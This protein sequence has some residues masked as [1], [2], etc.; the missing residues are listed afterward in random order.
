M[1]KYTTELRSICESYAGLKQEVGYNAVASVIEQAR[2]KIFDFNY[3][4]FDPN[5]KSVLE[6][7]IIQHYYT[8][9]ISVETVGLWK[10]RLWSKMCDIMPYYNQLYESA[11]LQYNPLYDVEYTKEGTRD[12]EAN[13]TSDGTGSGNVHVTG[14]NTERA[15]SKRNRQQDETGTQAE[16]TRANDKTETE[17]KS[18]ETLQG[19]ETQTRNLK[20]TETET[21]KTNSTENENANYDGT[22]T[23][24]STAQHT[25]TD[26]IT[27][28]TTV[29]GEA[30][31]N[32]TGSGSTHKTTTHSGSD[33]LT[34]SGTVKTVG[35]S[36][37]TDTE[38]RNLST[39]LNRK[40]GTETS[41]LDTPQNA[42]ENLIEDGY[43]TS[44]TKVD[45][46]ENSI[47]DET[48]TVKHVKSDN[49]NS[50]STTDLEHET[51]YGH[52]ILE[53]G[54]QNWSENSKTDTSE[55]TTGKSVETKNLTDT[56]NGTEKNKN[57]NTV[58]KSTES[59]VSKNSSTDETGT[60]KTDRTNETNTTGTGVSI[61]ESNSNTTGETTAKIKET[62]SSESNRTA[63]NKQETQTNST[64]SSKE[65]AL[66]LDKYLEKIRGRNGTR[67]PARLIMEYRETFLN[68]DMMVIN[69]LAE[70]FFML[71]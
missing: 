6:T 40:T 33:T 44:F 43:L 57:T 48:G 45:G 62:D 58:D 27:S 61:G 31:K 24:N 66:T 10:M 50:T 64:Q 42:V 52:K 38:T 19:N 46:A 12:G 18:N 14:D 69:D 47:T 20:T 35:D 28:D 37:G 5:Y 65:R 59:T 22:I 53:D 54:T 17:T 7:K 70:L 67:S 13:K 16:H 39:E 56:V 30:T 36:G 11:A 9:E 4:I 71:W 34:D 1:A 63:V 29:T 23:T 60:L 41:F 51:Q 2:P 3:P 26:T 49:T 68:I 15:N 8:R 21:T 32:T 55:T 25:G